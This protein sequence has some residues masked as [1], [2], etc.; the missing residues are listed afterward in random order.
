MVDSERVDRLLVRLSKDLRALRGLA[1]QNPS[2]DLKVLAAVKYHFITAI[3]GCARIAQHVIVSEDWGVAETNAHAIRM[4]ARENVLDRATADTVARAIGFRN[5]L[6]HEYIDVDEDRVIANLD[7]LDDLEAFA[8]EV[9][10][11]LVERQ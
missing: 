10:Q 6:V 1:K 7:R 9:A 5:I 8:T 3:E 11:W 2:E 4:L